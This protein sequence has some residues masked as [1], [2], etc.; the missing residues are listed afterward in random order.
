MAFYKLIM[1]WSFFNNSSE[2]SLSWC[3]ESLASF[4]FPFKVYLVIRPYFKPVTKIYVFLYWIRTSSLASFISFSKPR[5]LLTEVKAISTIF[6]FLFGFI[7]NIWFCFFNFFIWKLYINSLLIIMVLNE[8]M[9]INF[10][11][12]Y[13]FW[14]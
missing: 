13:I 12:I 9:M 4:I 14:K 3:S 10:Y 6:L 5:S 1:T 11:D 8:K 7:F 2:S